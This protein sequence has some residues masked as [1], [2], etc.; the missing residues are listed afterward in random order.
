MAAA[1]N[2]TAL[3]RQR[4]KPTDL[5]AT[6][7]CL[8]GRAAD[9]ARIGRPVDAPTPRPVT[10]S[11][12]PAAAARPA[13]PIGAPA[14]D[15][16]KPTGLQRKK[17]SELAARFVQAQR[18]SQA[19]VFRGIETIH[20][21]T[22]LRLGDKVDARQ[23]ASKFGDTVDVVHRH[24]IGRLSKL[25][26]RG[27]SLEQVVSV[28]GAQPAILPALQ[29]STKFAIEVLNY[30]ARPLQWL[31]REWVAEFLITEWLGGGAR[32]TPYGSEA[33]VVVARVIC[34]RDA[35]RSTSPCSTAPR[36]V[37]PL[38]DAPLPRPWSQACRCTSQGHSLLRVR[39]RPTRSRCSA[40]SQ[41]AP[42]MNVS[43][44]AGKR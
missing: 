11:E 18:A 26:S 3:D 36:A 28:L 23:A 27:L 43:R 33:C 22:I 9:K 38:H 12:A 1:A 25:A 20:R 24:T 4:P 37:A 15:E 41:K 5:F 7:L 30:V 29:R 13:G 42:N 10:P 40:S 21:Q 2:S 8:G 39:R 16:F 34:I 17:L 14:T 35:D 6:V 31:F 32:H 44:R 19:A